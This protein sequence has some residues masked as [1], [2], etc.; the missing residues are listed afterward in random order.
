ML[1][2]ELPIAVGAILAAT[3]G[4]PDQPRCRRPLAEGHRQR[5]IH[6]RGPPMMGQ[7]PPDH[8][9]RAQSQ[10]HRERAPT[11]PRRQVGDIADVHRICCVP[12]QLSVPLLRGDCLGLARSERRFECTPRLT[13][14]ASLGQSASETASTALQA[15]L[16]PAMLDAACAV[17]TT[18]LRPKALYGVWPR[19]IGGRVRAWRASTPFVRTP[20]RDLQEPTQTT[21]LRCGVLLV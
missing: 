2:Q 3:I 10:H 1:G 9:S 13:A 6:P 21:H 12:R 15:L 4:M 5:L 18:P 11:L 17:G 16:R 19:L 14:Q 8:R 20:A 7:G